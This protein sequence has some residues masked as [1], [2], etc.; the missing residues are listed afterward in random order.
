MTSDFVAIESTTELVLLVSVC[1]L[2]LLAGHAWG[3]KSASTRV[4]AA[5]RAAFPFTPQVQP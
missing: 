5:D 3:R 4:A 2:V 1:V